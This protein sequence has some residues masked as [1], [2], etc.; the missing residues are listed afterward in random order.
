M[1]PNIELHIDELILRGV[2]YA[3][4][5]RIV[6]AIEQELTRLLGTQ[7]L[8]EALVQSGTI[9]YIRLDDVQVE[10]NAKPS[11]VGSQIARQVYG[12]LTANINRHELNSCVENR[13]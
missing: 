7:G 10:E 4:R 1:K 12:S 6:A 8:P 9:P 3:Q 13:R 2:P 5:R 11:V